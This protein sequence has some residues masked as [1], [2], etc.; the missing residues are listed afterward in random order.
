[1]KCWFFYRTYTNDNDILLKLIIYFKVENQF[2]KNIIE[3]Y[4]KNLYKL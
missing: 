2:G 3:Y 1:M 4:L